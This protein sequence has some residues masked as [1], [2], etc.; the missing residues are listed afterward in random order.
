[1]SSWEM[2]KITRIGDDEGKHL[3]SQNSRGKKDES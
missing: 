2:K 3:K 1:M